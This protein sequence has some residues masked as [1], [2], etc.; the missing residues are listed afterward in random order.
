MQLR[1]RIATADDI[2][3]I[4]RLSLKILADFPE[5][6]GVVEERVRLS[7]SGCRVLDSG[8]GIAGYV[9][10]H[11]WKR[12]MPPDLDALLGALPADA[13]CWYIHDIGIAGEAR[14][15]GA[16]AEI[17]GVLEEL[18]RR[19]GF[20]VIALVAVGGAAG[21]WR[22]FGFNDAMTDELRDALRSYGD[23]AVYME[24]ALRD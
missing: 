1:W 13:D 16:A 9:I 22:R 5:H 21:Y 19:N 2:G 24:K 15:S 6:K 11:P 17:L 8:E 20:S 7:A 3:A 23:D 18:A 12:A 4:S 14:G 10:S